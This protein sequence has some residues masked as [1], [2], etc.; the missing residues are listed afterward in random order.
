MRI[1]GDSSTA[2]NLLFQMNTRLQEVTESLGSK[3]SEHEKFLDQIQKL[4][5]ELEARRA[6]EISFLP[7]KSSQPFALLTT[8][9]PRIVIQSAASSKMIGTFE[10]K[11]VVFEEVIDTGDHLP[12]AVKVYNQIGD[13]TLI[14]KLY[15]IV[16]IHGK[17]FA[18]MQS[19]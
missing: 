13:I 8:D 12:R 14:Q 1:N 19:L 11:P 2:R 16:C 17:K 10:S 5:N 3:P 6:E 4:G 15:G 18:M 9:N 7:V